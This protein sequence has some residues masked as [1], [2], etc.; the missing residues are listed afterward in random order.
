[1]TKTTK[2][3]STR[4]VKRM[5]SKIVGKTLQFKIRSLFSEGLSLDAEE[6]IQNIVELLIQNELEK[7]GMT[8][9]QVEDFKWYVVVKVKL[10]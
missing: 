8:V 10:K 4:L 9:D 7:R 5:M 3:K 6:D 1:M 2:S